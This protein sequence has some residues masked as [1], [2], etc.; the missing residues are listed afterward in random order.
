[1]NS[2][3]GG[4]VFTAEI[5]AAV[6]AIAAVAAGAAVVAAAVV[7]AAVVLSLTTFH[8]KQHRVYLCF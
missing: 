1:L 6:V 4:L 5:S 2:I 8:K 3:P 7:V